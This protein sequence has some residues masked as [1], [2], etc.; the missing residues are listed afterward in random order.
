MNGVSKQVP[1]EWV[2]AFAGG[3][4][5]VGQRLPKLDLITGKEAPSEVLSPVFDL[6]VQVL[7]EQG[8]DGRPTGRTSVQYAA[9]PVLLIGSIDRLE[10]GS[11]ATY[12]PVRG[13]SSER[14]IM[15]AIEQGKAL[16]QQIRAA[17]AGLSLASALP[18]IGGKS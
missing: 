5:L 2:I 17:S 6:V 16:Q 8:P 13:C 7:Q 3:R 12:I 4:T 15:G 9:Q 18:R 10:L 11:G 1:G 14:Q